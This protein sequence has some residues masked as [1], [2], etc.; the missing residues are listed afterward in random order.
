LPLDHFNGTTNATISLAVIRKPAAVPLTSKKYGGAIMFNPGGP[1]GSGVS[2]MHSAGYG[3]QTIVDSTE[4]GPDAQ[5]FDLI[6]FDPRGIARS[7]PGVHCFAHPNAFI[8]RLAKTA[9]YGILETSD[10][11]LDQ[12]WAAVH[13]MGGSCAAN[14]GREDIKRY[15]S[16]AS[17]A[18]DMLAL[19]EAHG[20]WR[21]AESKKL[22]AATLPGRLAAEIT[23]P[24]NLRHD[25]DNE[26]IN[27]WGFSY[28]TVLGNTFAAL[29]PQRIRR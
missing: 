16:T 22:L 26:K 7:E 27:Y 23:L 1:G 4:D 29:Y 28:G 3:L 2:F 18:T 14:A 24:E 9:A 6:S 25:K 8:P 13:A 5:Y 20:A 11:V 12:Q 15:V 21:E 10:A 19:T 17:V